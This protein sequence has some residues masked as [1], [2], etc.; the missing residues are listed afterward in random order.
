MTTFARTKGII[1]IKLYPNATQYHQ[2]ADVG[3]FK[4]I[5][6]LYCKLLTTNKLSQTGFVHS[7]KSFA[8]VMDKLR[9]LVTPTWIKN[10]FES[11][12]IVPWNPNRVKVKDFQSEYTNESSDVLIPEPL[13]TSDVDNANVPFEACSSS[14]ISTHDETQLIDDSSLSAVACLRKSIVDGVQA[15]PACSSLGSKGQGIAADTILQFN[16]DQEIVLNPVSA[17]HQNE[18]TVTPGSTFPVSVEGAAPT[19]SFDYTDSLCNFD[20]LYDSNIA[21]PDVDLTLE[22][23]DKKIASYTLSSIRMDI[24]SPFD[25]FKKI[26]GKEEVKKYN[27]E[28]YGKTLESIKSIVPNDVY[29]MM[30]N[31]YETFK[32]LKEY[33]HRLYST[34]QLPIPQPRV[35]KYAR[36][37]TGSPSY[38]VTSQKSIEKKMKKETLKAEEEEKKK[39]RRDA[40][41]KKC[42]AEK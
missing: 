7:K 8:L 33:D 22:K 31:Q 42:T 25:K 15:S 35:R 41:N 38:V 23:P 9:K 11:S 28:D 19:K 34:P 27:N 14:L 32:M 40:K 18:I 37:R 29:K 10:A 21:S 36:K 12:G 26:I 17:Y 30:E 39:A 16:P 13:S 5:K 3:L 6:N 4:P 24:E 2:P 20:A 1:I